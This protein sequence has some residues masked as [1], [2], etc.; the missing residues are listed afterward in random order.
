[1][2]KKELIDF[3]KWMNARRHKD[4]RMSN[5]EIHQEVAVYL[6]HNGTP[7]F[8]QSEKKP[9]KTLFCNSVYSD[10]E[11]LKAEFQK[12]PEYGNVDLSYYHGAVS[13]WSDQSNTKRTKRGWLAT[14]RSFMRNDNQKGKLKLMQTQ[15]DLSNKKQQYLDYMNRWE[16]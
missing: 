12:S 16:D 10:F 6:L 15:T 8:P 9:P 7:L 2:K 11:M 4:F 3:A 13:D 1:M 5:K 14:I